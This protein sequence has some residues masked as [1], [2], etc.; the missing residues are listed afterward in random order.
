MTLPTD[1]RIRDIGRRISRALVESIGTGF[2]RPLIA[3]ISGGAD[4]SAMLLLLADTQSRHGWRL[5]TAHVDHRIQTTETREHFREKCEELAA[6]AELPFECLEVDAPAEAAAS[7]EGLEAAARHVRYV[8][9][10]Q[11][12]EDRG[13][14]V[15]AVAHTQDDQA[16]TVLMHII[17]GSGLD[18]LSGMPKERPL[19]AEVQLVRPLLDV[20]RAETE[21]VC[22]AYGWNP[23]HD[24]SN[25]ELAH[26]RNRIR[27]SLIPRMAEINPNVAA[28]VAQLARAAESD[29][30]LLDLIGSQ[31]LSQLVDEHGAV[32]RRPFLTLPGQLQSRVVR[33]LC[34]EHGLILTAERTAAA[35]QVIHMGHGV[36]EFPAG[37]RLSVVG[38]TIEVHNPPRGLPP[39]D[40]AS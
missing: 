39:A 9:L 8:G 15:V 10:T 5:R 31:T 33:A 21:A 34:R 22:E 20:T 17:R 1:R 7:S 28:R 38:G 19:N 26:T 29:R 18:G 30:Q 24:P 12:A 6:I 13:A 11:L 2:G 36:V 23:V 3:A 32:P 40:S 14:P 37:A 16:E 4:S 35:L 25:D 27:H